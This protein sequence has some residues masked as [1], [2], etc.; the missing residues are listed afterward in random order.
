[1]IRIREQNRTILLIRD[2]LCRPEHPLLPQHTRRREPRRIRIQH[3]MSISMS[4]PVRVPVDHIPR[5]VGDILRGGCDARDGVLERPRRYGLHGVLECFE[6]EGDGVEAY[7]ERAAD[8]EEGD[9]TGADG[10]EFGEAV[11][12]AGA[13]WISG[14]LPGGE[15]DEVTDE[16]YVGKD[17]WFSKCSSTCIGI[18]GRTTYRSANDLH[19][20]ATT[21]SSCTS[22]RSPSYPSI[23]HSYQVQ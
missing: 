9:D 22:Q 11:G 14:E 6:E 13:W 10:F 12:V 2:L 17:V 19:L 20:R 3:P 4:M 5:K 18:V 21:P 16:V 23:Q 1:M 7:A 15:D 8:E